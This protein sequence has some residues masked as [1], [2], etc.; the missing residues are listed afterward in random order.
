MSRHNPGMPAWAWVL[1]V[2]CVCAPV[3]AFIV[4]FAIFLSM[5]GDP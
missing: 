3:L 4:M 2:V 5:Y 1:L